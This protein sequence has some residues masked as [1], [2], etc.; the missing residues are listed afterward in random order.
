MSANL[1]AGLVSGLISVAA[2]SYL[3]N[4]ARKSRV[5]GQLRFGFVL[6]GLAL[7]CLAFVGATIGGLFVDEDAWEVRTELLSMFGLIASFLA[8][9]IFCSLEYFI[10]RGHYDKDGICLA[11]PWSGRRTGKWTDLTRVNYSRS[12]GWYTLSFKSG[13]K[14][15]LS[16]LLH[17]HAGVVEL[18]ELRGYTPR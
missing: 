18:L 1:I 10:T 6:P 17:G 15:R 8:G 5:D 14:I 7:A 9:A 2:V 13:Q 12:M 4:R 11:T 16:A 3:I